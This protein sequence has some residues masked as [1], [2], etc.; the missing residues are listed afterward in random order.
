MDTRILKKITAKIRFRSSILESG[1]KEYILEKKSEETGE[2]QKISRSIRIERI[3]IIKHNVWLAQLHR[4]NYTGKLLS[5][6]KTG[7]GNFIQLLKRKKN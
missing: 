3:L 6:R 4:L 7:K 2:W 1:K 5:R